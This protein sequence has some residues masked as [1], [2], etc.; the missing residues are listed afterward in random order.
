[1][2]DHFSARCAAR[3]DNA[4][5][6][7]AS[8]FTATVENLPPEG[9]TGRARQED[10]MR[11]KEMFR[12]VV[13]AAV[14]LVAAVFLFP[15]PEGQACQQSCGEPR[16]Y[17]KS[18]TEIV[19]CT[20]SAKCKEQLVCFNPTFAEFLHWVLVIL[21]LAAVVGIVWFGIRQLGR[22]CL[23]PVR[24]E[25]E[26]VKAELAT[27]KNNTAKTG[28]I[29]AGVGRVEGAVKSVSGSASE[30]SSTLAKF[31]GET[32][33]TLAE[34]AGGVAKLP[35]SQPSH[36]TEAASGCM[37]SRMG[38]VERRVDKLESRF[39][40]FDLRFDKLEEMIASKK[41]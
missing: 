24:A 20:P 22:S 26:A 18:V 23:E 32:T 11:K 10:V 41:G 12:L 21:G 35:C 33:K 31:A 4:I 37:E 15:L 3:I 34:I 13:L 39:D 16:H 14:L 27:V 40:K 7:L 25:L 17:G 2:R 19:C 38:R 30:I 28:D 9:K 5:I 1:M 36:D 6:N 8:H 29:A